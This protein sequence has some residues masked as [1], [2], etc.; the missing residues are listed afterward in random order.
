[1]VISQLIDQLIKFQEEVGDVEVYVEC[2]ETGF[3]Q[4]TSAL[5]RIRKL[6]GMNT[7]VGCLI[8]F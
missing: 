3:V 2:V 1:M 8:E 4:N 6:E 5:V 7:E